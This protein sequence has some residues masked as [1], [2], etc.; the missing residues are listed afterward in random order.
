MAKYLVQMEAL[1]AFKNQ[2]KT[3]LA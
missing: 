2:L 1:N 3:L